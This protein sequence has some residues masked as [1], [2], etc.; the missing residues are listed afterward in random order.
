[1]NIALPTIRSRLIAAA[2][3]LSGGFAALLLH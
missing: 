3:L 2:G 1:M